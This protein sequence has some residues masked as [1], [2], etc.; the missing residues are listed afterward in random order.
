[1]CDTDM[2][3]TIKENLF[4][5]GNNNRKRQETIVSDCSKFCNRNLQG[6]LL[7]MPLQAQRAT[8]CTARERQNF[9]WLL[10]E[11]SRYR[12]DKSNSIN[13]VNDYYN[14]SFTLVPVQIKSHFKL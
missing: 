14:V 1:M 8:G 3:P 2:V 6:T 4:R 10:Q 5:G 9:R 7:D 13:N 11:Y 12:D